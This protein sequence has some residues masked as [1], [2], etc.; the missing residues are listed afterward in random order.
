MFSEF[1]GN[2]L[3]R[4]TS[5]IIAIRDAGLSTTKHTHFGINEN[6][7]NVWV[8]DEDWIGCVFCV[9]NGGVFWCLN[10]SNCG[11]E[12]IFDNYIEM[13]KYS[14]QNYDDCRICRA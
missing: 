13:T 1:Y 4:L 11:N 10:C 8:W 6:S 12:E 5:C 14:L 7:G 3:L 2:D 9:L